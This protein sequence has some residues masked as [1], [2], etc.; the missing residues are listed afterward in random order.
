VDG[1]DNND[2]YYDQ[3]LGGAGFRPGG[4]SPFQFSQEAVQ[5][6]QVNSNAYS[7]ELG[8]ASGGVINAVTKSGTNQFHGTGFWFYR[9]Q[10]MN[11]NDLVNKLNGKPKSPFHFNDF[12]GVFG[13]PLIKHKLFFLFNYDGRRSTTPN[14]VVLNLPAGFQISSDPK[15]AIFQRKALDYLTPRAVSWR[16]P[17]TQ[18]VALTKLDWQLAPAHSLSARWTRQRT[19]GTPGGR[20]QTSFESISLRPVDT[21]TLAFSLTSTLSASMVNVARFNYLRSDIAFRSASINPA[22]DVFQGGQL[23]LSIGGAGNRDTEIRRGQWSDVLSYLRGRHATKLGVDVFWIRITDF[24]DSDFAGR[25]RFNSL[26]SFG[27]SLA[28]TP[29]P[30]SGEQYVQAFSGE[31]KPGS[32]THP[33]IKEFSGFVQDE[34]RV[35]PHLT[36]NTGLRYD[37]RV[38]AKPP[39]QN[40]SVALAAAGLDTSFLRTD[41]TN[42]APRFGFA[43]TPLTS[44][45]LVVRGGYGVFFGQTPALIISFASYANGVS[46]Q[47]RTFEGGKP[48]GALIP[49]YPNTL[50]GPPDPSG[51]P[52]S[53][54]APDKG[55]SDSTL[56]FFYRSYRQPYSQ[57]G[58]FGVEVQLQKDLSV[59][60]NYLLV[61]GTH[62]QRVRDVNLGTPTTPTQ[63]G[64]AGTSDVLTYQKFTQPRPIAGFDR[65]LTYQSDASSIYHGLAMQVNKRL[66]HNFQLLGSYTFGKVIDDAPNVYYGGSGADNSLLSDATNPRADRSAG[67]ND[68]RHT[69]VLSG[70]WQLNY[71]NALP[72]VARAILRG[73][74]LSGILTAQSGQPYSGIVNTDLNNDG[75]TVNDRTPGLGRNTFYL[76]RTVSFDPRVSRALPLNERVRLQLI[77]EAFNVFNRGNVTGVRTTQ[78]SLSALPGV[79]GIAGRPCLVPQTAGLSAF[80]TPTATSGPRIMELSVK[81]LF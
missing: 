57:Q 42:L 66:S 21:D 18:N 23:V 72:A 22:A 25:Y 45:R 46:V 65:L 64:I 38:M 6:F 75:N 33:D 11:A 81:I 51:V 59:A 48:S 2:A 35:R 58:S 77:W 53:C 17:N 36:L 76:P 50:C 31:G 5:E 26:V 19:K 32:T 16:V 34:W 60:V 62:L 41:H 12:G 68:R 43:W 67:V 24:N 13:G 54:A 80:G 40:Q 55:T 47:T 70:I 39:V 69:F 29:L 9:D 61:K 44:N 30:Q 8:H 14:T 20:A 79:C 71:A 78:F 10:S 1:F 7:A 63:I 52:P 28:G 37:V 27:Q 74:E 4:N 73:W 3:P 56:V 15:V 49:A